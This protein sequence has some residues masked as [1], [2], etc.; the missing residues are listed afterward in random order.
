MS[1]QDMLSH[2]IRYSQVCPS[3]RNALVYICECR[4]CRQAGIRGTMECPECLAA[5][6]VK[7]AATR[8]RH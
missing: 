1:L 8:F 2:S 6:Y 7:T 3:C 5:K 4:D